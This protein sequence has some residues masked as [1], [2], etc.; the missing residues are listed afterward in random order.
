MKKKLPADVSYVEENP[1][2]MKLLLE[3]EEKM[4]RI[5]QLTIQLETEL[6]ALSGQIKR[7]QES[8]LKRER[9]FLREQP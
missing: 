7:T 9:G 8:V 1:A 5:K 4:A 3:M 2:P 6:V